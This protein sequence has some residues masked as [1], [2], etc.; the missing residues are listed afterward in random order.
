MLLPSLL[1][2]NKVFVIVCFIKARW[3]WS[4]GFFVF[5][6]YTLSF[7]FLFSFSFSFIAFFFPLL[8]TLFPPGKGPFAS[9]D[10]V[11]NLHH[12]YLMPS[13]PRLRHPRWKAGMPFLVFLLLPIYWYGVCSK[14]EV[15][16]WGSPT[17]TPPFEPLDFAPALK[18]T[19]R[20]RSSLISMDPKQTLRM[21]GGGS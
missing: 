13:S 3:L 8:P 10:R 14:T 11:F 5:I 1:L 17:A 7:V 12:F 16:R 15:L 20:M 9:L 4:T 19:S 21:T 18:S 6:I 2:W